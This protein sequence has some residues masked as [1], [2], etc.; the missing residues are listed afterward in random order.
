M[1]IYIRTAL[2]GL[3]G[4]PIDR[5]NQRRDG[6]KV[7]AYQSHAAKLQEI[8]RPFPCPLI[9]SRDWDSANITCHHLLSVASGL[10]A[11]LSPGNRGS[12]KAWRAMPKLLQ[13][14]AIEW[15]WSA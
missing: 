3:G 10:P 4:T 14:S 5:D 1:S 13:M 6:I 12:D 9:G 15:L 7:L 2:F 11:A 8:L